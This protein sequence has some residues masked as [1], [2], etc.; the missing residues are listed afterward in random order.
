LYRHNRTTT[1]DVAASAHDEEDGEA[2][3]EVDVTVYTDAV[4]DN[5]QRRRASV[6]ARTVGSP[7]HRRLV[8]RARRLIAAS[9]GAM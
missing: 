9:G 1:E 2:D 6:R 5:A 4:A 8:V 3:S 7:D